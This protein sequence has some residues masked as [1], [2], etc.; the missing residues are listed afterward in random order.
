MRLLTA[1]VGKQVYLSTALVLFGFIS[2]DLIFRLIVEMKNVEG[3]YTIIL[4]I[5]FEILNTPEVIYDLMPIVGLIGCLAGLG[6]LAGTSELTVMRSAGVPILRLLFMAIK[7]AVVFLLAAMLIGELVAPQATYYARAMRDGLLKESYNFDIRRGLWL[8]DNESFVFV[9]SAN[10]QGLMRGIFIFKYEQGHLKHLIK[11]NRAEYTDG[12]WVLKE[13]ESK[14]FAESE[15]VLDVL[16]SAK[17]RADSHLSYLPTLMKTSEFKRLVWSTDIKPELLALSAIR[18][19]KMQMRDLWRYI[20]YLK[21]QK[22]N[23][24]EH[25][26]AFWKKA[27]YPLVMLSL[28]LI[29]ISFVF[30]SLREVTMGYRLFVGILTGVLFKILQDSLNPV[31][32]IYGFSPVYSMLAP[33][34]F[35]A[36]VGMA[37]LARV[38]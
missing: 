3:D 27:Y 19:N 18:P 23:S 8:R 33:A 21:H 14:T 34:L 37:L 38:K 1:Y 24:V 30:G 28:V 16:A 35:S 11:A 31:T 13:G 25:E 36:I 26:L 6:S 29:G 12:Q 15:K 2:L 22:L 7:P 9:N 17:R 5:W 10:S 32:I 4:A 20:N